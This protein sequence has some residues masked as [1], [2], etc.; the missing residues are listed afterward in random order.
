MRLEAAFHNE[1]RPL[2][3]SR[4]LLDPK[5]LNSLADELIRKLLLGVGEARLRLSFHQQLVT[6]VFNRMHVA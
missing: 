1:I 2:Y 3:F 4:F 6:L 5:R